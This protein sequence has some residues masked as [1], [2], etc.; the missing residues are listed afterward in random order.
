MLSVTQTSTRMLSILERG[1]ENGN[2]CAQINLHTHFTVTSSHK[3]TISQVEDVA[4]RDDPRW[5]KSR[6]Q[7]ASRAS[8]QHVIEFRVN[9]FLIPCVTE[10]KSVGRGG[11]SGKGYKLLS[12]IGCYSSVQDALVAYYL[13]LQGFWGYSCPRSCHGQVRIHGNRV[14]EGSFLN[15]SPSNDMKFY[16]PRSI[17]GLFEHN[18]QQRV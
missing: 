5:S 8:H 11:Q 15:F 1:T 3:R 4:L 7:D 12:P 17:R 13:N 16:G 10:F 18:S 14:I 6:D 2:H 9:R